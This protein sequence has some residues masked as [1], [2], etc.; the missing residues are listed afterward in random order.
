MKIW[1]RNLIVCWFGMFVTSIGMSQ[2]APVMPLY[3]K[4]LGIYD[5]NS[6]E[7]LSGIAFGITF[8]VSAVFSPI[9]GEAADKYGRKLMLLRASF[10]M[11]VVIFCMGFSHNV[12]ELIVLRMLQGVITGYSTA[13]ITLIATQTEREHVG[14]ALGTLSTA[15]VSGSLIGP[16][17]GGYLEEVLGLQSVFFVTGTLM[18]I[19]FI[20]TAMFVK[21]NF[22]PSKKKVLNIKEAW[23]EIPNRNLIVIMFA[24]AFILQLALYSIEPIVTVYVTKLAHSSAHVALVSG[25]TFSVSGLASIIVAPRLGKL[26]DRIGARKV[27][28]MALIAAGIIFIPQAF[29]KNPWQLMMLRFVLGL[30]TAGLT[31]SVNVIVRKISPE[32][33]IGRIFGFSISAQ[34]LGTF[35][36]SILGGQIASRF[37]IR[38]V[39]IV[40]GGLLLANAFWVYKAAYRKLKDFV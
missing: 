30:A 17:I 22:I 2:I 24:T 36:G 5:I 7:Q 13:C 9:W 33:L 16:M 1:K 12:Y 39:F 20:T 29:V 21:E 11:S 40:T 15:S 14:F 23:N 26:S 18:M 4:Y 3:I 35:S 19:V 32:H 8:V 10:G 28:L 6:I 27:I 38:S 37:G 31:P 25:L 34:Y